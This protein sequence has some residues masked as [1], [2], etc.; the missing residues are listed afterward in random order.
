MRARDQAAVRALR[1]VLAAIANAE[2]PPIEVGGA[3]GA[4]EEAAAASEHGRL[5]L[6]DDDHRRILA[7]EIA[8]REAA[9]ADYDAVGQSEAAAEVR[10]EV[11]ALAAYA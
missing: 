3:A 8:E 11:A 9:A 4:I 5:E 2:A 10:A 6:T 1:S 7:T